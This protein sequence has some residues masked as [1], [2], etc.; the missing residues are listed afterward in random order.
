[1]VKGEMKVST[2]DGGAATYCFKEMKESC[3]AK[4]KSFDFAAFTM[5]RVVIYILLNQ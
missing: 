1:M 2:F 4:A 3:D 5:L